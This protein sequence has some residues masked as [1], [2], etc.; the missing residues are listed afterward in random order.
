MIRKVVVGESASSGSP[1][2]R[3]VNEIHE[4]VKDVLIPEKFA[5]LKMLSDRYA[6]TVKSKMFSAEF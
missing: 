3:L 2:S 1:L 4:S 6:K 5:F